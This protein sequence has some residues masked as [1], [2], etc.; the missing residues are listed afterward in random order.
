MRILFIA[1]PNYRFRGCAHKHIFL[2]PTYMAGVLKG[3]HDVQFYDAE[4]PYEGEFD[5]KIQRQLGT[6]SHLTTSHFRY[7]DGLQDT[8][9]YIWKEV[10]EVLRDFRPD[11]VGIST[12]TSSY[13][14]ALV[15]ARIAKEITG[16]TVLMGG[17]HSNVLYRKVATEPN[18]DYVVYGEGERT[19]HELMSC[20]EKGIEPSE[21]AG[22]AYMRNNQL[23]VTPP[24]ANIQDLDELPFP[25]KTIVRHPERYSPEDFTYLISGR[26]CPS[27]CRF[28]ANSAN[29]GF[30]T[31]FRH[32]EKVL[33][34]IIYLKDTYS[35]SVHFHDDNFFL[36][37]K[38]MT[39][40]C[41]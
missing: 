37:N 39:V 35:N 23:V 29:W 28:C 20:L 8:E 4:A 22:L 14:S 11:V 12:M 6:Y 27:R 34:E 21:V 5:N 2:G 25:D 15:I 7:L 24:R 18:V 13:P 1:P 17:A 38:L 40:V 10:A 26:G 31:R 32:P 16:A 36:S 19:I 30:K 41:G 9:H 3:Y 33:E